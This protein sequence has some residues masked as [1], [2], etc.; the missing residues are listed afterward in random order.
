MIKKIAVIASLMVA[1][2]S[3]QAVEV[4]VNGGTNLS[5]RENA[6]GLTLGDKVF[7]QDMTLGFTRSTT[8]DLYSLTDTIQITK[9]GPVGVGVKFGGVY[10]D[11]ATGSD[12]YA[13]VAG[14]TFSVPIVKNVTGV[15]DYTYQSGQDSVAAQNGSRVLAGIKYSF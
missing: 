12:G 14:A 1:V 7:G 11:S 13:A 6:W 3:A 2:A 5:S 4:G 9:I 15:V 10:V 8:A